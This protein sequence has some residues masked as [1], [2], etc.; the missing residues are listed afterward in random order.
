[1]QFSSRMDRCYS[2]IEDLDLTLQWFLELE[3]ENCVG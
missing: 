1:M 3:R 2:C